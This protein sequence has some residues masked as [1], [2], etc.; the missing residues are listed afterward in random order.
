M[1]P[2]HPIDP[3]WRRGALRLLEI[4]AVV[5]CLSRVS[6]IAATPAC[7][8]DCSG[9]GRV[10]VDELVIGVNIALGEK[11]IA[12][13]PA[14]D[15]REDHQVTVTELMQGINNV[16]SGCPQRLAFVVTTD[17]QTG[18]FA[19]V[20]L[21]EPRMVTP[22]SPA[23]QV[24]SDAV[25]RT[26]G[27]RVYIVN[28]LNGDNIQVLDPRNDFATLAQCSTGNGSN[29]ADIAFVSPTKA[30]V[31]RYALAQ[32]LI[33]NPSAPPD[34][35]G[36]ELGTIDLSAL[37]DADGIPEMDQMAIVNKKLYVSLQRL[38][39]NTFTPAAPG[40]LAVI[41]TASDTVA[42][43]IQLTGQNPFGQTKGLTVRDGNIVVAEAGLF[44]TNDGGIEKVDLAAGT[45]EGFFISEADLGGDV[46]DFALVSDQLGYAILSKAD[47]SNALVAFDATTHSVTHTVLA[48]TSL[49][50]IELDDR[51][52]LFVADRVVTAP[53]LLVF[54]AADGTPLTAAPLD[55]GLP[56]F[57]I[58]FIP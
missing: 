48:N 2:T 29:P 19:T 8:G 22:A 37:A 35:T 10:T 34:C 38:D 52:E 36:F 20:T 23:R 27:G 24:H 18:S 44:G 11:T 39:R 25:A 1:S 47:F 30:Y 49:S 13:C 50:D 31:T 12:A 58:V 56:A 57:D 7:I 53:G 46:T 41:D 3:T 33:V 45:A 17:F 14:F 54:R 4:V 42:G 6:A 51:G 40:A 43:M 26:F 55:L 32:L 9:D 28:R 15:I 5:G 16:F 21:D